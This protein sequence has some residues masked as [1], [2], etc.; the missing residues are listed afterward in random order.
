MVHD[1]HGAECGRSR[2][3]RAQPL[4]LPVVEAAVVPAG[5][6]GVERDDAQIADLARSSFRASRA[7]QEVLTRAWQDID[8]WLAA[9]PR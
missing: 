4:R 6:A 1:E 5:Q 9:P 2:E 3:R 7:P 8:A